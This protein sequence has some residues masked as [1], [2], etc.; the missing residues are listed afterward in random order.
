[1]SSYK[2]LFLLQDQYGNHASYAALDFSRGKVEK[3]RQKKKSKD[4]G[5]AYSQVKFKSNSSMQKCLE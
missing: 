5:C 3:G 4:E 1:M 2:L